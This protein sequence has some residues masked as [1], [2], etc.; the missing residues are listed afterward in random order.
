MERIGR[1]IVERLANLAACGEQVVRRLRH[2]ELSPGERGYAA[3]LNRPLLYIGLAAV[4]GIVI[5]LSLRSRDPD[6]L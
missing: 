2:G 5:G 1:E 4:A 3:P 6:R